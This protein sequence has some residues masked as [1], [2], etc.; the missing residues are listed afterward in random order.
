MHRNTYLLISVLAVFAAI[1]IGFNLGQKF[2]RKTPA[3][4]AVTTTAPATPTPEPIVFQPYR[5]EKCGFT[6]D[7]PNTLAKLD[8]ASGSAVLTNPKNQEE[9]IVMTCQYGIPRPPLTPENIESLVIQSASSSATTS[10]RL[11]HDAS[12]KDGTKV[13]ELIFR[14]PRTGIDIFIAGFG[15]MFTQAVKTVKLLP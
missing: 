4:G 8:N 10:A 5:N 7:Y 14:H 12:P 2:S 13:D 1:L 6:L 9:S 15:P 3:P 11:Y